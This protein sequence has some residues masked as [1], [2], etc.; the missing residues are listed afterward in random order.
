MNCSIEF[1]EL[2]K[3]NGTL[4]ST[5]LIW[6]FWIKLVYV[7]ISVMWWILMNV[8]VFNKLPI[9]W[10]NL[11]NVLFC[12]ESWVFYFLM[13]LMKVLLCNETWVF[14][15]LMTMMKVLFFNE[16]WLFYF[17]MNLDESSVLFQNKT[18]PALGLRSSKLR[19]A[20]VNCPRLITRLCASYSLISTGSYITFLMITTVCTCIC[21]NLGNIIVGKYVY[22]KEIDIVNEIL[23]EKGI[24][25]K[26]IKQDVYCWVCIKF[27]QKIKFL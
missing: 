19:R 21:I 26:N 16:S 18:S 22:V 8:L 5:D 15:F 17:L 4:I 11:M 12:N 23:M 1:D 7:Q 9:L 20:W 25:L 10:W 2:N 14:Y 6:L 24:R 27:G 13:T 3:L